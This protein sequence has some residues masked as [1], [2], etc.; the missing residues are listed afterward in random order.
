MQ[1]LLQALMDN[2]QYIRPRARLVLMNGDEQEFAMNGELLEAAHF[3]RQT[4][5]ALLAQ[6]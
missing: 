3:I 1:A 6:A 4:L 5:F 2:G